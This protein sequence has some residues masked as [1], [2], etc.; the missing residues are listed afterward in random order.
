M[1]NDSERQTITQTTQWHRTFGLTLMDLL[2]NSNYEVE[3]EKELSL[4]KQYLDVVIIRR[5]LGAPLSEMPVGLEPL[6]Q[7]NLLTYKSLR[8]PLDEWA[9]EELI[10]HYTNYRKLVSPSLNELLPVEHF[11]LY[12]VSTRYPSHLL[13]GKV[14]FQEIAQ[15]VFELTWGKRL[16]RLIVSNRIALEEKN[17]FWLLF[18]GKAQGFAYGDEHYHWRHPRERAVLNQLYELYKKEGVVMPYTMEDFNRDFTREHLHLLPPEER[19]RGLTPETIF[20]Q[21][22]PE[23]RL[24]GLPPETV[25]QQF[26]PEERLKGLSPEM[27]EAYLSQLKKSN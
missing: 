26:P 11:Q 22:S 24:K 12:A 8:E 9:I 16:I 25:F 15:G 17:A 10:G 27:I 4:K 19:L 7:H 14:S 13:N 1:P 21:F 3:L 20:K 23:E 6:A 2:A 5:T 18:S